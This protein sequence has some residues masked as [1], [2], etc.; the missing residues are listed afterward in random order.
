MRRNAP[1]H[2]TDGEG[3]LDLFVDGSLVAT[4]AQA[5]VI[6]LFAQRFQRGMGI[7]HAA[8]TGAQHV[9]GQVEQPEP[10]RM[11][12]TRDH[13]FFVEPGP[14]RKIQQVDAVEFVVLALVDQAAEWLGH[15]RIGSL[16]QH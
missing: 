9:P 16:L 15:R 12:E 11:Q 2:G 8:A 13:L 10:G 3:D 1:D 6:I 5:A 4:G 7:E 14:L